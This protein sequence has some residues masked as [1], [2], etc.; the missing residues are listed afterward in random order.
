ML[1]YTCGFITIIGFLILNNTAAHV[2][3]HIIEDVF[4]RSNLT[5]LINGPLS[6]LFWFFMTIIWMLITAFAMKSYREDR[7]DEAFPFKDAYWFSYI[8]TT[9]VG[10]GDI[11]LDH[12]EFTVVDMFF[13]PLIILMGFNFLGIFADKGM[14]LYNHYFPEDKWGLQ[15]I[16]QEQRGDHVEARPSVLP[17]DVEC[18]ENIRMASCRMSLSPKK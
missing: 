5:M 13:I 11:H 14:D 17:A 7:T 8:T 10:F 3:K 2:W 1:V 9:T 18:N 6:V 4:H 16:L 12:E 15:E